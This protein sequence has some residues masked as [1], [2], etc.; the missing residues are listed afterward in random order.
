MTTR[1][2]NLKKI[3]MEL[4]MLSDEELENVAGGTEGQVIGDSQFLTEMGFGPLAW[5]WGD[6][7]SAVDNGWAAAGISS[8]TKWF[9]YNQYWIKETGKEITR[10]EAF[11]YVANKVGKSFNIK[12]YEGSFPSLD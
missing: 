12:K 7:S 11:K 2:E 3:N 5:G 8:N 1:E 9:S 6:N 10:E 4:E